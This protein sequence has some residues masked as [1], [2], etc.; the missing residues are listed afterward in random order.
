M[1]GFAVLEL[2][3][4]LVHWQVYSGELDCCFGSCVEQAVRRWQQRVFLPET[5]IVDCQTWKTL[6]AGGPVEMP[7]LQLGDR[8][9]AVCTVQRVLAAADC[10]WTEVDGNFDLFTE[11]SVRAFQ[12]RCGLVEDGIVGRHTWRALSKVARKA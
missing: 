2:Q 11:A 10:F 9:E 8:G 7:D 12:R 5:G 1:N 6:I 3:K 4:L